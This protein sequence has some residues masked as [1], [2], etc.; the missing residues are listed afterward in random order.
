M[1]RWHLR[2][3][4]SVASDRELAGQARSEE[5]APAV[6]LSQN[7]ALALPKAKGAYWMTLT[8]MCRHLGSRRVLDSSNNFLLSV[9]AALL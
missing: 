3:P 2:H 6:M 5:G 1:A 9:P 8:C 7:M 4:F